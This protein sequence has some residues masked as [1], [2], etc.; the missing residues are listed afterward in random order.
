MNKPINVT[1]TYLPPLK[2]YTKYLKDIWKSGHVTNHG[3]LVLELENK[4]RKFCL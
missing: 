2:E 3:P 4:L 1:K